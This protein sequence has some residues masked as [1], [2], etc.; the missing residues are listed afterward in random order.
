[1]RT[2]AANANSPNRGSELYLRLGTLLE[3]NREESRETS[4]DLM[5]PRSAIR[6][7]LLFAGNS[8]YLREEGPA[9]DMLSRAIARIFLHQAMVHILA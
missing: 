5:K 3:G 7:L 6:G 2:A 9:L 1:L 8:A 4:D